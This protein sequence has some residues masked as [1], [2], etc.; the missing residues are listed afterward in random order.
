MRPSSV[1]NILTGSYLDQ[2]EMLH[3]ISLKM[4]SRSEWQID[5]EA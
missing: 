5:A 4:F 2:I 1:E 3:T